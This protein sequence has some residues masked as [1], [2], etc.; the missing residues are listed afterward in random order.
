[1]TQNRH[2]S[3][4]IMID[5]H[6]RLR[7]YLMTKSYGVRITHP[8]VN[9]NLNFDFCINRFEY[10]ILDLKGEIFIHAKIKN[11]LSSQSKSLA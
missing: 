1:M 6:L 9:F 4:Q 10:L 3:P 7:N 5:L 2:L 11:Q 8:E